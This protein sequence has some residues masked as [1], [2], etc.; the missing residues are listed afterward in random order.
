MK[1][2][3]REYCTQERKEVFYLIDNGIPFI[4]VKT[5]E[6]NVTTWKF[7]KGKCTELLRTYNLSELRFIDNLQYGVDLVWENSH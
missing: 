4:F 7:K 5:D 3:D 1:K 6:N 2:I